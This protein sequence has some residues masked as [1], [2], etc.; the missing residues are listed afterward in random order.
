[1]DSPMFTGLADSAEDI[2]DVIE[3]AQSGEDGAIGGALTDVFARNAGDAVSSYI[4]QVVRQAAQTKDGYYRDTR[5]STPVETAVN[6]VKSATPGIAETL[7]KKYSGLG[8]EQKR[9]GAFDT[10]IDPTDTK[11]FQ[12]NEIVTYLD[13]LSE[14]TGD[15]TIYPDRQAPMKINVNEKEIRLDGEAREKYQKT[16]G[17]KVTSYYNEMI[18][19][20]DFKKLPDDLK[21]EVMNNAKKYAVD[22]AKAS[23]SEWKETPTGTDAANV[24]ALIAKSVSNSIK[25]QFDK[26]KTDWDYGYD[27]T[28]TR[29]A[30]ETA[31][32]NYKNLSHAARKNVLE[33]AEGDAALYIQARNQGISQDKFV[34]VVKSMEILKN[35][36]KDESL[37]QS[38]KIDVVKKGKLTD[39]EKVI[40][41][42]LY[43]SDAQDKNIDEVQQLTRELKADGKKT[44]NKGTFDLYAELYEDHQNYTKGT[45]KK[46]RTTKYWEQKH[47]IDAKTADQYYDLFK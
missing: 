35:K 32:Q 22:F 8:E 31:F 39:S 12:E 33:A 43:V 16:Y 46:N 21:S 29:T 1:M 36:L 24:N 26:I 4:P 7:P 18:K 11:R 42:K 19:N 6:K 44:P 15:D 37:N 40:V 41:G 34:G 20:A 28:E 45:G 25:K 27:D 5:G 10:F 30:M 13:Q 23:V 38:Q 17:D 47:G 2:K 9:N 3:A 14:R